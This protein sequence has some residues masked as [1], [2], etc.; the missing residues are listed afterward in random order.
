VI[1]AA[2]KYILKKLDKI[3]FQLQSTSEGLNNYHKLVGLFEGNS[4]EELRKSAADI[5]QLAVEM[6][7]FINSY[8]GKVQ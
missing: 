4:L 3:E 8:Y 7:L 5:K 2:Q 6:E 1:T